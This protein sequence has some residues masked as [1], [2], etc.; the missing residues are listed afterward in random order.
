MFEWTPEAVAKITLLVMAVP[1]AL[2]VVVT[3]IS[4]LTGVIAEKIGIDPASEKGQK[5]EAFGG[6]IF[7]V[8]FLCVGVIQVTFAI[9]IL[10]G[11]WALLRYLLDLI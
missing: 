5:I 11:I 10:T 9:L 4:I 8:A 7:Y 1:F 6:S 2:T 3:I